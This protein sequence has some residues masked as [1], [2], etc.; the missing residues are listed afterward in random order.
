MNSIQTLTRTQWFERGSPKHIGVYERDYS[1]KQNGSDVFFC[2]FDGQ[3]FYNGQKTIALAEFW[4]D[5]TKA[6]YTQNILWRGYAK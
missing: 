1:Q 4:E 3:L 2:W 5:K 6:S